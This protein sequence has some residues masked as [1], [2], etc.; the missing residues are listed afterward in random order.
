[1]SSAG[2]FQ[3]GILHFAESRCKV[4][5]FLIAYMIN[6]SNASISLCNDKPTTKRRYS[7]RALLSDQQEISL[8]LR[9]FPIDSKKG[10][11]QYLLAIV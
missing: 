2:L 5:G 7:T 9:F 4:I 3:I 11:C 10:P 6:V 8:F 1:M